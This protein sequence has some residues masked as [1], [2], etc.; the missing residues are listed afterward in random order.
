MDSRVLATPLPTIVPMRDVAPEGRTSPRPSV[1]FGVRS[2]HY[3]GHSEHLR[4]PSVTPKH[5]QLLSLTYKF[6]LIGG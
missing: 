4:P 3:R 5:R 6:D 1:M 2:E